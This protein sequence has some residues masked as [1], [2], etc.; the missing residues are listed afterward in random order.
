[1]VALV[2]VSAACGNGSN[3][4]GGN[5]AS[6]STTTTQAARRERTAVDGVIDEIVRSQGLLTPAPGTTDGELTVRM[7][8]TSRDLKGAANQL[9]RPDLG[10]PESAAEPTRM[11]LSTMAAALDAAIS[12]RQTHLGTE[13]EP[14]KSL[15]RDRA[16]ALGDALVVLIPYG[17]RS[18]GEISQRRG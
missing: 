15:V 2:A 11:A 4:A 17:T 14:A 8:V 13:C 7:M 12:C 9:R 5:V 1:M 10:V 6:S 18:A 16:S 3:G